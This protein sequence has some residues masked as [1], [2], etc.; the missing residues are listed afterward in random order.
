MRD[1]RDRGHWGL[2]VWY[3]EGSEQL[4]LPHRASAQVFITYNYYKLLFLLNM[5]SKAQGHGEALIWH[6]PVFIYLC[7]KTVLTVCTG[8][9]LNRKLKLSIFSWL[10]LQPP[11]PPSTTSCSGMLMLDVLGRGITPFLSSVSFPALLSAL[12][13]LFSF[14]NSF[15][16]E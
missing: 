9:L 14:I 4:P 10:P 3:Q 13:S 2:R 1:E 5:K 15:H 6:L 8:P 11:C 7:F 16:K 12:P